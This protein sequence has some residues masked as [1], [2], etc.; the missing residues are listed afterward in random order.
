[1]ESFAVNTLYGCQICTRDQLLPMLVSFPIPCWT[2]KCT[3]ISLC[4]DICEAALLNVE[5]VCT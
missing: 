3:T 4:Q 1:M 5:R 2:L